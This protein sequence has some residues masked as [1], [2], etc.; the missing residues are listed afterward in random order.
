M[1]QLYLTVFTNISCYFT[2]CISCSFCLECNSIFMKL[3]S[4]S[5]EAFSTLRF[6]LRPSFIQSKVY[7]LLLVSQH[8]SFIFSVI[9]S[10][11][12]H[13]YLFF[14]CLSL[15]Q[16]E[17]LEGKIISYSSLTLLCLT[18]GGCLMI[19]HWIKKI[20]HRLWSQPSWVRI[21]FTHFFWASYLDLPCVHC[22]SKNKKGGG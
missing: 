9:E 20:R 15:W 13:L 18:Y 22:L 8:T 16:S 10:T 6:P 3:F 7:H 5:A 12:L 17:L 2:F 11:V 14:M 19:I 21:T 4:V 1:P